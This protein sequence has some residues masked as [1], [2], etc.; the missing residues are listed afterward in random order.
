MTWTLIHHGWAVCAITDGDSAVET[1]ASYVTDSPEQLLI[2][3]AR[4]LLGEGQAEAEFE[5]EPTVF[6]WTFRRDG[7]SVAGQ[8]DDV[9]WRGR[10]PLAAF[11]R[12][13]IRAF[14]DVAHEH[15]DDGYLAMWGRPFPR[16]ELE[17][18]RRAWR[19]DVDTDAQR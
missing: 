14:D 19:A 12:V 15:G 8:V 5:A 13:V 3:V 16:T 2:A 17:A 4:L 18:L 10:R 11:A 9:L 7:S 6:R 1:V